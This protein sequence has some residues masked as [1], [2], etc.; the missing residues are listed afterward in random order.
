MKSIIRRLTP[1]ETCR[2]MGFN[3][4]DYLDVDG[5]NTS[6]SPRYKACGNS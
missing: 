1:V 4:D 6:D 5:A 3:G 2:L